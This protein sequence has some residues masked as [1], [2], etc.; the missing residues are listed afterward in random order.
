MDFDVDAVP[1]TGEALAHYGANA[2]NGLGA[3]NARG[4]PAPM[5]DAL[6]T[7]ALG[8]TVSQLRAEL[9]A[10]L[11]NSAGNRQ[12]LRARLGQN[13]GVSEQHQAE[14]REAFERGYPVEF[15]NSLDISGMPSHKLS[16]K[17]GA[18]LMLLRNLSPRDGLC[19]GT[20]FLLTRMRQRVLEGV[21]ISGT[22]L[23]KKV[24]VPRIPLQPSDSRFPFTLKRL[25]FPVK[26]AFVMTINKSQGQSLDRVGLY[27]PR[28][29]FGHG[30]LYV[31]LSR[32]GNPPSGRRGVRIVAPDTP[33]GKQGRFEGREGVYTR[34][35][36]YREVL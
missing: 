7:D 20:R 2:V 18:V 22:F 16:A 29:V 31:A 19:N 13:Y 15:L 1:L 30:Q 6:Y 10:R 14:L 5:G 12:V 3:L 32:S 35:V 4:Y 8:M 33:D 27:L 25:Q 36:V 34:N 11:I 23:G 24:V 21:I 9:D 26:V 28:P 17:R